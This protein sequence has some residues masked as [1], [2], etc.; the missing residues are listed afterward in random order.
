MKNVKRYTKVIGLFSLFLAMF[1]FTM[2]QGGFVSWFLFYAVCPFVLYSLVL[3][4]HSFHVYT[5]ERKITKK[6][7]SVGSAVDVYV[8]VTRKSR[9]PLLYLLVEEQIEG[10]LLR[11]PQSLLFVGFTKALTW[12][13]TLE[14]VP[15]GEHVFQGIRLHTGDV[16][17][18]FHKEQMFKTEDTILVFPAYH[19]LSYRE[20]NQLWS[21]EQGFSQRARSRQ[22]V[23][24]GV[25]EYQAGD[26]LSWI[27]WKATAKTNKLMTKEFDEQRKETFYI[28]L[29]QSYTDS[30]EEMVS[31]V[32]SFVHAALKRGIQIG[33]IDSMQNVYLPTSKGERHKREIF[34]DLARVQPSLNQSLPRNIRLGMHQAKLIVM[35]TQ[36]TFE[37]LEH[38]Y[39]Y[40]NNQAV[41]CFVVKEQ[42]KDEDYIVQEV[43]LK[44]GVQV[45]FVISQTGGASMNDA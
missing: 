45:Q 19:E 12:H 36:L 6:E 3:S 28:I 25:R 2:F 29:D 1:I 32:A 15:R 13:Y 22:S 34:Y 21:G 7:Y 4:F 41:T 16:L 43:A 42:V 17:G 8:T 24:S 20:F 35:T 11:P 31:F 40:R 27:N 18:L 5:V 38:I 33:W 37:K 39:A 10:T 14:H 9:F 23:I 30:F 44:Q 26:Q